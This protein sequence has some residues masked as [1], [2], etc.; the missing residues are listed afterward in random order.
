MVWGQ[1]QGAGRTVPGTRVGR[2]VPVGP[3]PPMPRAR[4]PGCLAAYLSCAACAR[5]GRAT[6]RPMQG[7]APPP[8]AASRRP[9]TRIVPPVRRAWAR[10]G[11][12]KQARGPTGWGGADRRALADTGCCPSGARECPAPEP[13]AG[14]ASAPVTVRARNPRGVGTLSASPARRPSGGFGAKRLSPW[15]PDLCAEPARK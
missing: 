7:A 2:R 6:V 15:L 9:L 14:A 8:D 1:P 12:A 11:G 4:E 3:A 13:I 10:E 5:R